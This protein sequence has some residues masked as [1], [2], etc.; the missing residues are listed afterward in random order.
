M[1]WKQ[2][3]QILVKTVC[4]ITIVNEYKPSSRLA[5]AVWADQEASPVPRRYVTMATDLSVTDQVIRPIS[6]I[7]RL[8]R[9]K[10]L[11]P[12]L[13]SAANKAFTLFHWVYLV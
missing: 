10:K 4:C 7:K 3:V 1:D 11:K 5:A 8:F 9:L 13:F 12:I 6:C 2:V